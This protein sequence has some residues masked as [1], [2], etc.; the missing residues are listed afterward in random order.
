M[1]FSKLARIGYHHKQPSKTPKT[2]KANRTRNIVHDM[3]EQ[4]L[5]DRT[6]TVNHITER[7]NTVNQLN[8]ESFID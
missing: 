6:N 7:S 2:C 8:D 1:S 5:T 3:T 4:I